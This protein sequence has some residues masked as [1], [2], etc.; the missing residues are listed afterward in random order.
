VL[1]SVAP[2]WEAES[3]AV[4]ADALEEVEFV[5][6]ALAPKHCCRRVEGMINIRIKKMYTAGL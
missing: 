1:A 4:A 3:V 2:D 5:E 6:F